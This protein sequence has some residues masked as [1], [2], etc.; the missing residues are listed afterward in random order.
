MKKR[1]KAPISSLTHQEIS[2]EID[3]NHPHLHRF[4][5]FS[6]SRKERHFYDISFFHPFFV[7]AKATISIVPE[8]NEE[9][10]TLEETERGN[11]HEMIDFRS[12]RCQAS[13]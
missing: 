6:W 1:T 11:E 3:R 4:P 7:S 10:E 8:N 5:C 9:G 12:K 2:R 13:V